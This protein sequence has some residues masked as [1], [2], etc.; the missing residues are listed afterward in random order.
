[1]KKIW[2]VAVKELKIYFGSPM[3][4]I[5]IA[6]FLL[7]TLF[8]FFWVDAFF[9]R[10]SADVRPLFS[11]LP[12]LLIFLCATL[13]MRQWSEERRMGTYEVLATLPVPPPT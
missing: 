6:V 12:L 9:A 8:T 11:R 1:M 4:A 5:F 10:G 13:T 2:A 7:F 3:A